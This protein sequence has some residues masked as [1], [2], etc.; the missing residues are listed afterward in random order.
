M[1]FYETDIIKILGTYMK[2]DMKVLHK[3]IFQTLGDKKYMKMTSNI[4][5]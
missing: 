3:K 2:I 4:I 5:V 1:K